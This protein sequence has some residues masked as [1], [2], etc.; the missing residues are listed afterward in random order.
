MKKIVGIGNALVDALVE[1]KD[2]TLIN[3][4]SLPKG[5]ME[6][7]DAEKKEQLHAAIGGSF[8]SLVSGGAVANTIAALAK[9][10]APVGYIGKIKDDEMGRLYKEEME[11]LGVTTHF[12]YSDVATG[13][14]TTLISPDGERTFGT[15]LGAAATMQPEELTN[16]MFKGY[17]V[18]VLE[19]YLIFNLE[20]V[21]TACK[22]AKANGL[23]ITMDMASYNLVEMFLE[24]IKQILID[25]VDMI[26]LNEEEMRSF[27]GI[28]GEAA[29]EAMTQYSPNVVYKLG[30][31]GALLNFEGKTAT[32]EALP[33]TV[34]DTTGAGDTY[35]AGIIYG[36]INQYPIEKT[37]LLAATIASKCV[38]NIGARLHEAQ[39]NEILKP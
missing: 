26:F 15:Y 2:D 36:Y 19:G 3:Q 24:P 30:K 32:V 6:M 1:I 33:T 34:V 23:F 4:F 37:G 13:V 22:L 10:G 17:D 27:L 9:L 18:L 38:Q 39:W 28:E 29:L 25:Y 5:G 21:H 7:I 20:L 11:A 31:D 12:T 16:D 14:A 8:S 35:A